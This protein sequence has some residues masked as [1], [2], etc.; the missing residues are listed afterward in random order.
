MSDAAGADRLARQLES[1]TRDRLVRRTGHVAHGS[2]TLWAH[3]ERV[4]DE[5]VGRGWVRDGP[6]GA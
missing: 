1:V 5:A 2:G 4:I 6:D 3:C